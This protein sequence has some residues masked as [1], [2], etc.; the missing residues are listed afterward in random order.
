MKEIGR[1][2]QL[3][4][5]ADPDGW[6]CRKTLVPAELAWLKPKLISRIFG[7]AEAMP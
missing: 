2:I 6:A 7:I 4:S 1:S 5:C 3:A